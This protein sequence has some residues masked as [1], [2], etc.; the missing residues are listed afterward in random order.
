VGACLISENMDKK[1]T[2]TIFF[3]GIYIISGVRVI[4]ILKNKNNFI[5]IVIGLG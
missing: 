3:P 5:H 2:K 1:P 4:F